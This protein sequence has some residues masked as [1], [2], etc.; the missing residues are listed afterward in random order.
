[1]RIFSD[2]TGSNQVEANKRKAALEK[3]VILNQNIKR[4]PAIGTPCV[5]RTEQKASTTVYTPTFFQSLE[6]N[7]IQELRKKCVKA[8]NKMNLPEKTHLEKFSTRTGL[9]MG[10][11]IPASPNFSVEKQREKEKWEANERLKSCR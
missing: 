3:N 9:A 6:Q 10:A 5:P 2:K 11:M 1:M 8:I 7:K 4:N